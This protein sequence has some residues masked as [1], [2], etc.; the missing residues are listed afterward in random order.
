MCFTE[1][2]PALCRQYSARPTAIVKCN[3]TDVYVMLCERLCVGVCVRACIVCSSVCFVFYVCV[4]CAFCQPHTVLAC[5][6]V[7]PV[8]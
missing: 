5:F 1:C 7:I 2:I 8:L 6:C 4:L 3:C